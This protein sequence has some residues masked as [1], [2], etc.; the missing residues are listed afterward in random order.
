MGG[1]RSDWFGNP[2]VPVIFPYQSDAGGANEGEPCVP[3]ARCKSD[4]AQDAHSSGLFRAQSAANR[5]PASHV[6]PSPANFRMS[7]MEPSKGMLRSAPL[8]GS[9]G[10]VADAMNFKSNPIGPILARIYGLLSESIL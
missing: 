2:L 1:G 6:E 5:I 4:R 9:W 3:A 8:P 10:G 7:S